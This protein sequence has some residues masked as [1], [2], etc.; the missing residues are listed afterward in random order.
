MQCTVLIERRKVLW[1]RSRALAAAVASQ[2]EVLG[3][4]SLEGRASALQRS[5]RAT[6]GAPSSLTARERQMLTHIARGLTNRQI[7][8]RLGVSQHTVHRHVAN[9]FTKLGLSSRAAAVAF[10]VRNGLS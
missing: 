10:A 1:V 8:V 4:R 7:A 2:A 9:S 5:V 3:A 6:P